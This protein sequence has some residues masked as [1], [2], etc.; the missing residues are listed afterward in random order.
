MRLRYLILL[1][2]PLLPCPAFSQD[3]THNGKVFCRVMRWLPLNYSGVVEELLVTPGTQVKEGDILLRYTLKEETARELQS[4][5]SAG[6]RTQDLR[7]R[8]LEIEREL[9]EL[10]EKYAASRRL[11]DARMGSEESAKRLNAGMD[12]LNRQKMLITELIHDKEAAFR[13]RQAE[14]ES[15]LGVAIDKGRI[16]R[17]FHLKTPVA[18]HVLLIDR[19]LRGGM[20]FLPMQNAVAIGTVDPMMIRS[21]VYEGEIAGLR[22]GGKAHVVVPS[23]GNREFEATIV[24]ID[25]SPQDQALDRPTYYGVELKVPNPDL[26]LLQ[27]FKAIIT[28]SGSADRAAPP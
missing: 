7:L 1:L 25:K 24:H 11:S 2:L 12:I 5:L 14:L 16:P 19:W 18:G 4:E 15:Q 27:G 6:A 8:L 28:F 9:L 13:S 20:A 21:Q 3:A 22:V 26:S 17:V 10:G 23:L